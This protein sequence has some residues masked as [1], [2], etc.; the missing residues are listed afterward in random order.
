MS[1]LKC[2]GMER[3]R[4]SFP[5]EIPCAC[6]K[7]VEMWPD[8]TEARCPECGE[9]VKRDVPPTCIDWCASA[10]ECVGERLYEQYMR[11]RGKSRPS[12]G[13]VERG[14]TR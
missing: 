14:G 13:E 9:I 6:G 7:K 10:R 8:D 1:T 12:T 2:P 4:A 5:D 11:A 3:I